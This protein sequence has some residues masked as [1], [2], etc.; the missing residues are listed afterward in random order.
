MR[1]RN[2]SREDVS[3]YVRGSK[4]NIGQRIKYVSLESKWGSQHTPSGLAYHLQW[5]KVMSEHNPS[6]GRRDRIHSSNRNPCTGPPQI[7]HICV[8]NTAFIQY[9]SNIDI[10]Q[11]DIKSRLMRSR[12]CKRISAAFRVS[13]VSRKLN[14]YRANTCKAWNSSM[15][16]RDDGSVQ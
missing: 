16:L 4:I 12:S 8:T 13:N 15:H 9:Y 3:W 14:I 11:Q 10:T 1:W 7:T 2:D 6:K 5:P